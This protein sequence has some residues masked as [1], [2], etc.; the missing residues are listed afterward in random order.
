M[1]CTKLIHVES[2]GD[3]ELLVFDVVAGKSV[4]REWS[5]TEDGKAGAIHRLRDIKDAERR[6]WVKGV[7]AEVK[8]KHQ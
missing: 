7:L 1:A 3:F 6:E 5:L 4:E 2:D 8:D